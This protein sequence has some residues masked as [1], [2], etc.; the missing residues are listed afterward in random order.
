M[1]RRFWCECPECGETWVSEFVSEHG[2]LVPADQ[3]GEECTECGSEP[4]IQDEY[5]GGGE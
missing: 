3:Y 4:D 2:I 5:F 1:L